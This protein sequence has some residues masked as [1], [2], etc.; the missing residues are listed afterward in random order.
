[1]SDRIVRI[2]WHTEVTASGATVRVP[3]AVNAEIE[4]SQEKL[5][6]RGQP[7]AVAG[8]RFA[9][10]HVPRVGPFAAP[11]PAGTGEGRLSRAGQSRL[12]VAGVW[13]ASRDGSNASCSEGVREETNQSTT[14]LGDRPLL[15]VDGVPVLVAR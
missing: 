6:V 2:D 1:V 9:C 4:A 14:V 5:A 15:L 3:Q 7:V 11:L 13:A 12:R 10:G 8:D